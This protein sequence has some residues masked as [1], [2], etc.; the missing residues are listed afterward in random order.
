MSRESAVGWRL[1]WPPLAASRGATA[2]G[3]VGETPYGGL[4]RARAPGIAAAGRA[5]KDTVE[6]RVDSGA[7]R[8]R[9]LSG[10]TDVKGAERQVGRGCARP[11]M[12]RSGTTTEGERAPAVSRR[13]WSPPAG[14]ATLP[15]EGRQ[16]TR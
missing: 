13:R 1:R 9:A 12:L 10:M 3:A 6:R 2:S 8:S 4:S 15:R 7:G 5:I 14:A 11:A 16:V